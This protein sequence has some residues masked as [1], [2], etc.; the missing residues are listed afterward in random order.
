MKINTI[1][2]QIYIQWRSEE[3]QA[4]QQRNGL[5]HPS[6]GSISLPMTETFF[7]R[8]FLSVFPS[9]TFFLLQLVSILLL[10]NLIRRTRRRG[11]RSIWA[12]FDLTSE[13]IETFFRRE[14]ISPSF[15]D[16]P[17]S[18]PLSMIRWYS[19]FPICTAARKNCHRNEHLWK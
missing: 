11:R 6:E 7:S 1:N 4:E 13:L 14:N 2:E 12:K 18:V 15:H 10:D 9:S 16:H 8:C 19:S 3:G 5:P 17:G